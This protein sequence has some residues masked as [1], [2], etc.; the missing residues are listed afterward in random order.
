MRKRIVFVCQRYGFEVNGGAELH[1]RQLAERLKEFYDVEV[2]T[3]CAEDYVTWANRYKKGVEDINGITVRRFEVKRKRDQK[4]FE[5]LSREVIGQPH[6]SESEERWIDEQG[7]YSPECVEYIKEHASEY[8]A[9]IFMTY[10]YYLTARGMGLKLENAF[11]IPTAHDEAPIYLGCYKNVFENASGIIY[12]TIEEKTFCEKLFKVSATPSVIAG[13]GV[14]VPDRSELFD[15]RERYGLRDYVIY[16]G[17]IDK[18]KGCDT[19][20]NYFEEYKKRNG[21]ELKLVL[22]GKS[23]M[24]IP[25]RDDIVPLGFVSDEEKFSL[26]NGSK[27]LVLASEFESLSMVVLESMAYEKPVLVNGRCTVLK[28]HCRKSNAGLYFENYFEFEGALNYLLTHEA[29]CAVMGGY[30]KRYV[31]ENYRWNIIVDKVR[32]LID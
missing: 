7:P 9:V 25:Q 26:I 13:V 27:C 30:A 3:T 14:E 11:L 21:G 8:H 2:I 32:S 20:F 23:V 29:E 6:T 5:R 4:K 1:C 28:G 24:D 17:R 31:D 15:A 18:S 16:I 22:C 10:L 19:L 12:N